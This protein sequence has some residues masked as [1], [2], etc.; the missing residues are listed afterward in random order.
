MNE[1]KIESKAGK[2]PRRFLNLHEAAYQS[3][4]RALIAGAYR[5]GQKLSIRK[6]SASLGLSGTPVREA[7]K[8]LVAEGVLVMPPYRSVRVPILAQDDV[9]ELWLIRSMLEGAA[10]EFAAQNV[11]AEFLHELSACELILDRARA[12][13]RIDEINALNSEFHFCIYRQAARPRL[14]SE[15]ERHWMI[16]APLVRTFIEYSA[17]RPP[18]G[19]RIHGQLI[20]ALREGDATA[21]RHLMSLDIGLSL[22]RVLA[23][24]HDQADIP[25]TDAKIVTPGRARAVRADRSAPHV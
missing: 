14:L 17:D 6:V 7:F 4:R 19:Q 20:R 11:S 23:A 15:I 16:A 3:L 5:P 18:H 10:T 12:E 1:L 25:A 13:G 24:S 21:S 2:S 9:R 22:E 8:R